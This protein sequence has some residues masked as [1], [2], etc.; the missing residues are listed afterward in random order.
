MGQ[1]DLR[2]LY[3]NDE[4]LL[5]EEEVLDQWIERYPGISSFQVLKAKALK[6]RNHIN[7]DLQ[8]K[9]AAIFSPDRELLYQ[10]LIQPQLQESISK[11]VTQSENIE[12]AVEETSIDSSG[13]E[14]GSPTETVE[15]SHPENE[16]IQELEKQ[17]LAAAVSASILQ[18]SA[19]ASE[20]SEVDS[21]SVDEIVESIPESFPD[22]TG[23]M[24]W[25]K[26][27]SEKSENKESAPADLIAEFIKKDPQRITPEEEKPDTLVQIN[28][29]RQEF[30][31]P[32]NL[33]KLSAT[34]NEEFVT[35]TLAGIYAKQGH[36]KKAIKAYENLSL[37]F[38]EK[39]GYFAALINELNNKQ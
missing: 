4:L 34:D 3:Q 11:I 7:K 32:E 9:K 14:I 37:K 33:A 25:L 5:K 30:F 35:E 23:L 13:S 36:I 31:S 1:F 29:P 8:L 10:F 18:E 2:A 19:S 17:F 28:R 6:L 20:D 22:N 24:D 38:P 16:G 15:A 26:A 39:R 21:Q 12:P 27:T